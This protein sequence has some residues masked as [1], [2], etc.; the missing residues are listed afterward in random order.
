MARDVDEKQY[1]LE[2][3]QRVYVHVRPEAIMGFEMDQIDSTPI[4]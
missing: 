2:L 4:L 1:N 3:Q